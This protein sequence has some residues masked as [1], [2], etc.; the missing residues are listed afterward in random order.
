MYKSPRKY[1]FYAN[2]VEYTEAI[3]NKMKYLDIRKN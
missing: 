3:Q 2:N 1:I